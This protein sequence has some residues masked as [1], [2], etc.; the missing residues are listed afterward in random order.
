MSKPILLT[1]PD[2]GNRFNS[3]AAR[4]QQAACQRSFFGSAVTLDRC[5]VQTACY[6]DFAGTCYRLTLK[7]ESKRQ[8]AEP[9]A[10][11]LRSITKNGRKEKSDSMGVL[12]SLD[13]LGHIEVRGSF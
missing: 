2:Q 12:F 7:V 10:Y 3:M 4:R 9:F 11:A 1:S 8:T 5:L 6:T 13:F